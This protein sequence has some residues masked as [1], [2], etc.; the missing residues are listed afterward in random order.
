MDKT[1]KVTFEL[2]SQTHVG[3][4]FS[5]LPKKFRDSVIVEAL[6]HYLVCTGTKSVS[7][8]ELNSS[9]V[10][11]EQ[12]F[13]K[14]S[15]EKIHKKVGRPKKNISEKNLDVPKNKRPYKKKT[16]PLFESF[17]PFETPEPENVSISEKPILTFPKVE[18]NER[19][20]KLLS[21]DW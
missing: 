18:E 15:I 7:E 3:K 8:P 9:C 6:S 19:L 20:S 1:I 5:T 17:G 2:H 12:D 14:P 4:F 13:E 10:S 11:Q 21:S 16:E